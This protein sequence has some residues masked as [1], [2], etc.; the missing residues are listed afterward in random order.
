MEDLSLHVLD[1]AENSIRAGARSIEIDLVEDRK[2]DL[3]TLRITDD[4]EGMDEATGRRATDPFFSTKE[5]KKAGLGLA[6]L[7]QAAEEAGG[8]VVVESE[9]GRGTRV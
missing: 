5:G 8:R 9:K 1:V 4:G 7:S 6:L 2:K 3:L